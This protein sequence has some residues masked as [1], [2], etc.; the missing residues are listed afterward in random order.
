[1]DVAFFDLEY[2]AWAGSKARN[3]SGRGEHREIIEIGALIADPA[4]RLIRRTLS[5]HVRPTINPV[6]SDYIVRLTG[7]RQ[8]QVDAG[9]GF[10]AA[11]DRL[12]GFLGEAPIWAY[13]PADFEV[14]AEN[15]ALS[16]VDA[17]GV[18]GMKALDIGPAFAGAGVN[19]AT[20][21]TGDLARLFGLPATG[22]AHNAL[23]DAQSLA[24]AAFVLYERG[25]IAPYPRRQ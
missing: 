9:A 21:S 19:L 12:L 1:V 15:C 18:A 10:A 3:W 5:L 20:T 11:L 14:L 23:A 22:P 17:G 13:G 4:T 24:A 6:L 25:L 2:T 7:I 8:E 16:G